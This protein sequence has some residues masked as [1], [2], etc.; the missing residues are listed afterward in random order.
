[1]AHRLPRRAHESNRLR[2]RP[3][4]PSRRRSRACG[5]VAEWSKALAWKVSIRQKRIEGSNPSRSATSSANHMRWPSPASRPGKTCPSQRVECCETAFETRRRIRRHRRRLRRAGS[6]IGLGSSHKLPQR[7]QD[8]PDPRRPRV[9]F[10]PRFRDEDRAGIAGIG[11]PRGS[12]GADSSRDDRTAAVGRIDRLIVVMEILRLGRAR[13]VLRL[14]PGDAVV[15]GVA[16]PTGAISSF[17]RPARRH[18][19]VRHAGRGGPPV[20][21]PAT[22][23]FHRGSCRSASA[24]PDRWPG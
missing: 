8:H 15:R 7:V 13:P 22:S 1:M 24:G 16:G 9:T 12:N 5:A 11:V 20:T 14:G 10:D 2:N 3:L 18:I 21:C 17:D 6:D 23:H 19:P 4:P